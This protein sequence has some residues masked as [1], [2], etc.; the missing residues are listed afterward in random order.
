VKITIYL[1]LIATLVALFIVPTKVEAQSAISGLIREK[2]S[3]KPLSGVTLVLLN[4]HDSSQTSITTNSQGRY[5]KASLSHGKYRLSTN[6]LGYKTEEQEI[7]IHHK[8]LLLDIELEPQEVAIA[9]VEITSP[10][11]IKMKGDTMEFDSKKY[12]TRELAE[13]DELVAQIPGVLIDEEGNVS[14]HG[15]QVTRILIDGKEFFSSDPKIALK[16]LPADIIAKIQLIDEKSEQARFS[17][18]DDGKRNKIINI[19]TKPDKRKGQFGKTIAGKGSGNKYA[20]SSSYNRFNGDEKWGINLMGNNINETNFA[21]QGRGGSRR[22]NMNTDRGLAKTYAGALNYSNSLLDKSMDVSGD[23]NFRHSNT[24]TNTWSEIEYLTQK[25]ANQFRVQEQ[26][27]DNTQREHKFNARVKW[28]IDSTNRIDFSPNMTYTDRLNSNESNHKTTLSKETLINSANRYSKNNNDNFS[29]GGSLT[30]MHRFAKKGRTASLHIGGNYNS[31]TAE[32]LNLALISYYKENL[33]SR[34]DTNNNKSNTEGQG[35]GFNSRLSVTEPLSLYSRLQANYTF[36]NTSN[37]S[38]R[39][40]YAFL[41]ETGQLGELKERLSNAFKND[42]NYHSAG[43]AY[44]YNKQEALRLQIGANYQHGV[45]LNNR[46]V[47]ILLRTTADYSSFLPAFAL[48]YKINPQRNLEF[49]YN[50]QTNTPSINQLQDFVNNQNELRISN[51]NPNLNQEYNHTIKF[52]YRAIRK[53][54]GRTWT[55]HLTVDLIQHKI[56]NSILMTDT[57]MVLFDNIVLGAGGQYTVPIN[58]NGAYNIRLNNSYGAPIKKWKV[59]FQSNS[60]LYLY[61]DI[62]QINGILANSANYGFDQTVGLNSNFS[63]QYIIGLSYTL[64]GRFTQNPIA[65]TR[66]YQIFNHRLHNT[67][68]IELFNRFV[69]SSTLIYVYNGGILDAPGIQT[70]LWNSALGYKLLS[71]KNA[72]IAVKGYDLLNNVQ[73]INRRV[74]ENTISNIISNT[75]SR[76][77]MLTFTY[78]LRQFGNKT[79]LSPK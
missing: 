50:T 75:L 68:N 33:L 15:E 17:G 34:I 79:T 3:S 66:K 13:A 48:V 49:N 16:M 41:I 77:F 69:A 12:S 29:V 9:E 61:N 22:G 37:S 76:Y 58:V 44:I 45:R 21:E 1:S 36:R 47:P 24:Q 32:A 70:I 57:T 67:I 23:Y 72:E 5:S 30:Y 20:L 6:Y 2:I 31:N 19:V 39:E 35:S 59:N 74:N 65:A 10:A 54:T 8:P 62:S 14:A 26:V 56:A 53:E 28:T 71:R 63:K 42:Y 4:L 27:S 78:D 25:Q 64:D 7:R 18:F 51:G 73:N 60:R 52:Q 55:T 11:S 38:N 43:I 46:T 40:T